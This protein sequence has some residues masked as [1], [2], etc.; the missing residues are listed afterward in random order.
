MKKV[1]ISALAL[2]SVAGMAQAQF[3]GP[4]TTTSP[5]VRPALASGVSTT[6]IL[7]VGDSIGGYRM[8]GIPD[9]MGAFSNNDGTF[10]LLMNHEL[11][12]TVGVERAHGSK[13]AFVSRWN[14]GS[15]L[16]VNSG[17][18]HNTSANDVYTYNLGTGSYTQGTTAFARLCSA[19]LADASAYKFTDIDGTVYGTDSRIFMNG[20]ETGNEGRAFAHIVTGANTNQSWELPYL[21]KFS[22]ENSVANPKAQKK[23]IVV[24][25]DDTTPGQAYVYVGNK[26]TAGNDIQKAGLADGKL[27]GIKASFGA[28]EN[29]TTTPVNSTFSMVEVNPLQTGGNLQTQSTSLG[30]TEFLRPEDGAFDA[31]AGF[32]NNFYFVT[33]DRFST[34]T[35]V[36]RSRLWQMTFN[37]VANPEAGGSLK[38]LMQGTEGQQMFDNMCV[39]KFGRIL[40]Q[41]DVGNNAHLGKIW[42]YD[43]ATGQYGVVATSD[44]S[45]FLNGAPNFLT[46]DE[47]SSGIIDASAILGDGHYIIN[48][49]SHN[50]LGGELV[51]G[52]QLLSLFV[53]PSII[54]APGAMGVLAVGALAASRRRRA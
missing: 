51:E 50:S 48:M 38:M 8:V 9:G 22:W 18:D 45:R 53:D 29:R 41:E 17:R 10:T 49:Q 47:E 42:I 28:A 4:S 26:K 13:G 32:E 36:G 39:D 23:T 3:T 34:S 15:N 21:G 11:G 1:M 37:D 33:T 35:Q 19:D 2:V 24:G 12:A 16:V 30:V 5:Y 14:I 25:T 7:T 31:R 52:G 6:S 20:E 54:P 46:Q 27:Y 40:I 43:I 44:Q